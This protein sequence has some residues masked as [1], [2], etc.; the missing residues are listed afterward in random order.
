[1]TQLP[2][3]CSILLLA[4]GRGLRMGGRDKG[5]VPLHGQ[6]L[7]AHVQAVVRPLTDDLIISC[8]RN[9]EQYRPYADHLV[10][11]ESNDY[12]GPL[13]GVLSGLAQARHPWLLVLACDAPL[14]DRPLVLDLLSQMNDQGRPAMVRQDGHWQ[15]MF[16][17]LP[18]RLLDDLRQRWNQGER[19]LLRTLLA[20]PLQA[21]DYPLD[22]PR[23]SNFN[24]PEHLTP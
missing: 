2:A 8:N 10:G 19:S 16:C 23:L 6:P 14:I 5:L 13:A 20:Q 12:P 7:I 22:D 1:M 18:C 11:D 15:P 4:G 9:A 21:L 17:L 24:S 3:P